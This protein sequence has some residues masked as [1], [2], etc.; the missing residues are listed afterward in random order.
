MSHGISTAVAK[1]VYYLG[2]YDGL[3]G[4][5]D[6][7]EENDPRTKPTETRSWIL[8]DTCFKYKNLFVNKWEKSGFSPLFVIDCGQYTHVGE[9]PEWQLFSEE[10]KSVIDFMSET[11]YAFEESKFEKV[12]V[13]S[14]WS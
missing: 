9:E 13:V 7:E 8:T 3:V 11:G 6:C 1:N 14:R 10:K 2:H 5:N 4:D 12:G